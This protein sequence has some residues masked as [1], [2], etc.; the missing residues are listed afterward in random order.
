[1]RPRSILSNDSDPADFACRGGRAR[2]FGGSKTSIQPAPGPMNGKGGGSVLGVLG[3]PRRWAGVG[4]V[5]P[6]ARLGLIGSASRGC[7]RDRLD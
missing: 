6:A 3:P 5:L 4:E 1:M 7:G 2:A